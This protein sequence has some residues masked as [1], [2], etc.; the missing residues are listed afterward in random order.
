MPGMDG[1]EVT[2]GLLALD[3][4]V[5]V[6]AMS[7]GG[8][9]RHMEYLDHAEIFGAQATIAK[10]F[11]PSELIAEVNRLGLREPAAKNR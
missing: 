2:R 11:T 7:G 4:G 8:P 5:N 1:L 9:S 10:P 3:P 6:L